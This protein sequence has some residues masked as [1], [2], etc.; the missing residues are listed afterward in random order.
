LIRTAA[1]PK[2]K[3]LVRPPLRRQILES[4]YR[5][6]FNPPPFLVLVIFGE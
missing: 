2:T 4:S 3:S 5:I 1:A 6:Q